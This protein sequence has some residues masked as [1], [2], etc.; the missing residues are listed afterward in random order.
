[1]VIDTIHAKN[2]GCGPLGPTITNAIFP[3]DLSEV[4]T[5][6]PTPFQKIGHTGSYAIEPLVLND[7]ATDCPDNQAYLENPKYYTGNV[8]RC[9]PRLAFPM[10]IKRWGYPYWKHCNFHDYRFGI[11]DPPG[12]VL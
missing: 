1:M 10:N 2:P 3:F 5:L 6:K 11:Y 7:L 4:H 9:N 8:D 12:C